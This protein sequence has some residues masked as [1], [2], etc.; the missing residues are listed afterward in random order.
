MQELALNIIEATAEQC[1]LAKD[2]IM[3]LSMADNLTLPRPRMELDFLAEPFF[4]TGRKLAVTRE[5]NRQTTK[6]EL[7]ET[8]LEI[9]ANILADDEAWLL[10][11][12]YDF[13]ATLPKGANDSRGNWVKILVQEAT[14]TKPPTKRVGAT[15]IEV[16]TRV[17][18]LLLLRFIGRVTAEE[19]IGLITDFNITFNT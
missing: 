3:S 17:N 1:G 4:R 13:I 14:F 12:C 6:T 15:S 10:S 18:K 19:H 16:F 8:W 11:F 9:S 7:Y 2:K 5:N